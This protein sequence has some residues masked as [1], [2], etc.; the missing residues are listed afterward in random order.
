MGSKV[1]YINLLKKKGSRFLNMYNVARYNV[2]RIGAFVFRGLINCLEPCCF[3]NLVSCCEAKEN[4]DSER[5]FC[6]LAE[7]CSF[8]NLNCVKV[9]G[10]LWE[11][12]RKERRERSGCH[13][14]KEKEK[15]ECGWY[16]GRTDF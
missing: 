6:C 9:C 3:L 12:R 15:K 14:R 8:M 10:C 2:A 5:D 13:G 7:T 1:G 11:G 16:K 4:R